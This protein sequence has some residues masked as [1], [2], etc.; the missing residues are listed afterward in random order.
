MS[1]NPS[2]PKDAEYGR[3][4][5]AALRLQHLCEMAGMDTQA[6]QAR[7]IRRQAHVRL[8]ALAANADRRE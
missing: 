1:R 2:T 5:L 7:E 3:V 8:N 4:Y 6:A